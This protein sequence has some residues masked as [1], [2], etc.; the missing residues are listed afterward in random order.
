MSGLLECGICGDFNSE[1]AN[2]NF[3][4]TGCE[5]V[6][7]KYC[8]LHALA[9]STS[10]PVCHYPVLPCNL[11]LIRGVDPN[12]PF[13]KLVIATLGDAGVGKT[14]LVNRLVNGEFHGYE[15]STIGADFRSVNIQV[16]DDPVK[17]FL[18]DTG[19]NYVF[20]AITPQYVRNAQGIIIAYDCT[21]LETLKS[22]QGWL[23]FANLHAPEA[24]KI[25]MGCRSDLENCTCY[26]HT[27]ETN[28][29]RKPTKEEVEEEIS[30]HG[31]FHITTSA[32]TS[33]NVETAFKTLA[34]H[35]IENMSMRNHGGRDQ[36]RE[37]DP[38]GSRPIKLHEP[39][40]NEDNV[41]DEEEEI[42]GSELCG[43]RRFFKK[44]WRA[45]KQKKN[46]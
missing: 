43:M 38:E 22:V 24:E 19:G 36:Q 10:C 7:H 2:D 13:K 3:M 18:Q 15:I 20:K 32:K 29:C 14:G 37:G 46:M 44:F 27:S 12:K 41:A 35:I 40:R 17:L 39:P 9:K 6:F 5:H 31:L 23:D 4:V 25:I 28:S 1:F 11:A 21:R 8:I 30:L 33:E 34:S 45:D 16:G 42:K 26:K